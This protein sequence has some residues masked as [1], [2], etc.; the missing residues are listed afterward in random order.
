MIYS[1]YLMFKSILYNL[2]SSKTYVAI[3]IGSCNPNPCLNGGYC[4]ESPKIG[5]SCV[6]RQ[7]CNGKF[8]EN[9]QNGKLVKFTST[10]VPAIF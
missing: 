1:D 8:C 7:N 3:V 6:C 4:V 5:F 10:V 9:C 2:V